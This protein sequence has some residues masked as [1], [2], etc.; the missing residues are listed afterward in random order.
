VAHILRAIFMLFSINKAASKPG[1]GLKIRTDIFVLPLKKSESF[2]MNLSPIRHFQR[3]MMSAIK[4]PAPSNRLPQL[5]TVRTW[6][7]SSF[8]YIGGSGRNEST[9]GHSRGRGYPCRRKLESMKK[10]HEGR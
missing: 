6:R 4:L 3:A 2:L 10:N 8:G 5:G 7:A 9:T 1:G